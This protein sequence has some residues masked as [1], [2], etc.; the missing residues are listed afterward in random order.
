MPLPQTG[1]LHCT[2]QPSVLTAFASSHCSVRVGPS[3]FGRPS[4]Q[5]LILQF[6]VQSR[7]FALAAASSHC[8]PASWL[9]RPSP[10]AARVQLRLQV[11]LS[12]GVPKT[13]ASHCSGC[14]PRS[15]RVPSPH[16][17][18]LQLLRQ[19]SLASL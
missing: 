8:S 12:A 16:L 4:P 5:R 18:I 13:P 14:V 7:L 17:A 19:S 11:A 2:L 10:Q 3:V 6:A 9:I 15:F 1:V